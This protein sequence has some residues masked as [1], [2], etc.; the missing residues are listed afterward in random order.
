MR[1]LREKGRY[2]ITQQSLT[3]LTTAESVGER[4]DL[5]PLGSRTA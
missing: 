3:E 1:K 5:L 4:F 2:A